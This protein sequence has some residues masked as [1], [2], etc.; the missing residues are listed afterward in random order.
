[1][2]RRKI[3]NYLI[4]SAGTESYPSKKNKT[5]IYFMKKLI[6]YGLKP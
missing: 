6:P 5:E 2:K 3:L 4:N 1:M